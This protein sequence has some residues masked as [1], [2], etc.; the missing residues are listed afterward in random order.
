MVIRYVIR[1]NLYPDERWFGGTIPIIFHCVLATFILLVG[2]YHW[3]R[4]KTE[5]SSDRLWRPPM[6]FN[7]PISK[8]IR[9]KVSRGTLLAIYRNGC[10]RISRRRNALR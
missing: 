9:E 1:M 6:S 3:M 10:T 2:H 4:C 5:E 8:I 7:F